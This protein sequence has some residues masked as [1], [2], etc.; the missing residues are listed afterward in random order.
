MRL[1]GLVALGIVAFAFASAADARAAEATPSA[2]RLRSAADEYDKGRRFYQAGDFEQAAVHFENAYND[3]P[4][5]EALRN[6]IRSRRL[7]KQLSRAATLSALAATLY[8]D[9]PTTSA[10]VNEVLEEA[11]PKLHRTS[12]ACRP[13]CSIAADGRVV[14]FRD[15]TS[16]RVFLEPGAHALVVSWPGDRTADLR[17][18]AIAGGKTEISVDA[19]PAKERRPGETPPPKPG[20]KPLPPLVFFVAAGLTLVAG[21]A[22]VISGV[23]A[24]NN[25]GADAVRRDCVGLGENCPTYQD[26][27]SAEKRTNILLGVTAGLAVATAVVGV[28]FTQWSTAPRTAFVNIGPGYG[29]A[30]ISGRF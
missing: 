5:A 10:L 13:A 23:D 9:D 21:V 4:R 30:G 17:V 22:T 18:D 1:S 7:A 24:T 28:F 8:P 25:P 14:G 29:T 3:A 20:A 26:G 11:A 15:V 27:K 12:I 2:E 16:A 19:P 6:A